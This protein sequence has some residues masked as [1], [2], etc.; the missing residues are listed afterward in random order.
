[1]QISG[2]STNAHDSNLGLRFSSAMKLLAPAN[3]VGTCGGLVTSEVRMVATGPASVTGP[4]ARFS[5]IFLCGHHI[6]PDV[7]G[8]GVTH[9]KFL[10][11]AN[12]FS[13]ST[14]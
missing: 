12:N 4:R 7:I 1:M 11:T 2:T 13:E 10:P 6:W 8:Y 9:K 5:C 14:F 3:V